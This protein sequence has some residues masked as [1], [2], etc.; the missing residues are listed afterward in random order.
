MIRERCQGR[1]G[2]LQKRSCFG[3]DLGDGG[4]AL[5][6]TEN[7]LDDGEKEEKSQEE[8]HSSEWTFDSRGG[9]RAE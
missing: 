3:L 2:L 1:S 7:V 6:G 9:L 8:K 5:R 4:S